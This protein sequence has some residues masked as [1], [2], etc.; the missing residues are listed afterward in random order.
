[1]QQEPISKLEMK[2]MEWWLIVPCCERPTYAARRVNP[3]RWIALHILLLIRYGR[4][5][6]EA[7]SSYSQLIRPRPRLLKVAA[8]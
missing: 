3:R 5:T 6:S 8:K 4:S 1:M 2:W 7:E